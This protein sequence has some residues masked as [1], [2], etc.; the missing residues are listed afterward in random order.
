MATMERPDVRQSGQQEAQYYDCLCC[1]WADIKEPVGLVSMLAGPAVFGAGVTWLVSSAT[2]PLVAGVFGPVT[3]I[4]TVATQV[5]F[6]LMGLSKE[7]RDDLFLPTFIAMN[8]VVSLITTAIGFPVSIPLSLLLTATSVA[9]F[10]AA[11]AVLPD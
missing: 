8:I 6:D 3:M 10:F 1:D 7:A 5:I 4:A 11:A 2:H 9:G